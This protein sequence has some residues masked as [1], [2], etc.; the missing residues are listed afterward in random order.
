MTTIPPEATEVKPA[1]TRC[2]KCKDRL[3][4]DRI[5]V[6]VHGQHCPADLQRGLRRLLR[7]IEELEKRPV[8]HVIEQGQA[9]RL[10]LEHEAPWPT[11]VAADL[12]SDLDFDPEPEP[13]IQSVQPA[14]PIAPAARRS[15]FG[16]DEDDDD[17]DD[18]VARPIR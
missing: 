7:R 12:E 1:W 8:P 13:Y 18:D 2:P 4:N 9:E 17:D 5:D 15:P 14:P 11:D 16:D 10:D 6:E 3:W